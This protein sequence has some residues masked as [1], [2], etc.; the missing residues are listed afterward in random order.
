MTIEQSCTREELVDFLYGLAGEIRIND[1][2]PNATK[3]TI[4]GD[5][6]N[7]GRLVIDIS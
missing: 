5:S 1:L 4:T 3:F 2:H 6:E 7:P